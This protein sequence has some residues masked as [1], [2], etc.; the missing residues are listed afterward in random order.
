MPAGLNA[1]MRVWRVANVADDDVGGAILSGTIVY[2]CVHCRLTPYSASQL[3]L[4]QGLETK[5][6]F[7]IVTWPPTMVIYER[8]VVEII[9][10]TY[11]PYY[12]QRFRVLDVERTAIHPAD[13]RGYMTLVVD[14]Y[15]RTR[16][17]AFP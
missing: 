14:E 6:T 7:G 11:H 10:P 13:Q 4:Q 12:G 1:L 3:L 5:R 15:E 16:T 17:E 8:D 2:Q 9:G